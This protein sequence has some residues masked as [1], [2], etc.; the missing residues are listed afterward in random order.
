MNPDHPALVAAQSSWRCVQAHDKEGWLDLMA[1][2]ICMEDPI[3][4]APTNPTGEGM[5]GKAEIAEFFD[6]NMATST[7][8]ITTHESF[9]AGNESAHRMTLRTAFENGITTIV[10]GIFTYRIDDEGK[11]TNL[12]GFWSIEDMQ[13]LK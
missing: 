9:A 4:R 8:D 3:G 2:G 5:K 11:L 1:D 10:D 13:V 7:I 12:R 6:R